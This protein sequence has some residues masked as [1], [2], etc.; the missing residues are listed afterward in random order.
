MSLFVL[1]LIFCLNGVVVSKEGRYS[2]DHTISLI[3]FHYID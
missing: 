1:G 3:E 2:N